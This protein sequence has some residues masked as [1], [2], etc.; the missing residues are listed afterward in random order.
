MLEQHIRT[1]IYSIEMDTQIKIKTMVIISARYKN[2][3]EY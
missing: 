1:F 2:N 3:Y